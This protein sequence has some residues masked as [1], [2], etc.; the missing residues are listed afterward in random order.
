MSKHI[1]NNVNQA[2][3]QLSKLWK[4][5]NL[6]PQNKRKLYLML[7]QPQIVYPCIPLHVTNDSQMIKMQRVQ[8]K[9]INYILDRRNDYGETNEERHRLTNPRPNKHH[10][11]KESYKCLEKAL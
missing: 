9:A 8:N 7:V 11:S 2:K 3:L 10:T 1:T 6:S 5:R 4:F